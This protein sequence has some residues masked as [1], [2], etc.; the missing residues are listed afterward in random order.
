MDSS[1]LVNVMVIDFGYA[2]KFISAQSK[3]DPW[4]AHGGSPPP[5]WEVDP[6]GHSS[7]PFEHSRCRSLWSRG[8]HVNI[9]YQRLCIAS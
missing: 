3:P 7:P 8:P 9:I 2:A 5:K 4:L 6:L 1:S